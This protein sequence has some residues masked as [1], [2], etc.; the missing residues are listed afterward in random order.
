MPIRVLI[1]DDHAIIRDGLKPLIKQSPNLE[2]VGEAAN[3][4]EAVELTDQHRPDVVVVDITM[5][6]ID[7]AEATR[8]ILAQ[9]P[10]TKVIALSM[11]TDPYY[12]NLMREAGVVG[13]V[14]KEEAYDSLVEAIETV[15]AGGTA[16]HV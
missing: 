15:Y 16:F 5:P 13:Y 8:R 6:I 3:G 2:Q 7:G 14:P 11:H 4:L 9:H 1:A 12:V 10:Q